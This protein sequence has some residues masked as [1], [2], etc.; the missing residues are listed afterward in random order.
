MKFSNSQNMSINFC[1]VVLILCKNQQMEDS[2][3]VL[4]VFMMSL[5]L[6]FSLK[7]K[8]LKI[9]FLNCTLISNDITMH[10]NDLLY[11]YIF[12]IYF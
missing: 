3:L 12:E 1:S 4:L 5:H 11:L 2:V 9:I 8:I 6:Y 10:Y 7:L